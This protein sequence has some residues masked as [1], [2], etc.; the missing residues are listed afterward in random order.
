[1][2]PMEPCADIAEVDT[3]THPPEHTHEGYKSNI[4]DRDDAKVKLGTEYSV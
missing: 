1:M 4:D 3:E 2:V